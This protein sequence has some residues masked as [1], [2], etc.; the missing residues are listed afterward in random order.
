MVKQLQVKNI[1]LNISIISS[2]VLAKNYQKNV[3]ST[4]KHFSSFLKNPNN[5]TLREKCPRRV[6][7]FITNTTV[8]EVNDLIFDLKTSKST[9]P[10][11][12][13]T[14]IMKQLNYIIASPLA[15]LVN[16]SFQ[17]GIFPDIAEYSKLLRS[18]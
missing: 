3:S 6:T 16:K 9:G 14:K 17:S 1:S 10:S 5:L 11:S 15:E 18:F 8:E 13:P 4:K 2:Q 7:F 12:L